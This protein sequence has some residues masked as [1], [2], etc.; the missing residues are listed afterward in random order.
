MKLIRAVAPYPHSSGDNFKNYVFRAWQKAGGAVAP[1]HYPPRL[2]H[3]FAFHHELPRLLSLKKQE[4]RLRFVQ[5]YSLSFDTWPDYAQYEIVPMI[6]DCWPK[7]FERTCHWLAKHHV[8]TAIFTASQTAERIHRRFPN[9]H[10]LF[11]PEGVDTLLYGAGRPLAERRINLL[12][13]GSVVR[14]WYKKR[15]PV[16]YKRLCA[17][18]EDCDLNSNDGFRRVLQDVKVTVVFPRCMTQAEEAGDVETLTQRYWEAMLTRVVMVGHAPSELVELVGYNPV[19]ELDCERPTEQIEDILRRIN[20]YQ[21]LVDRNRQT[22]L[23][24]G[25]WL[26]R[27][28]RLK[29]FLLECGYQL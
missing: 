9:M 13:I 25:D 6:W 16:D 3:H 8:R 18:P 21:A 1:A 4:A 10:I 24:M 14:S 20:D 29:Q 2:L 15:Y 19:I 23:A 7:E 11:L 28:K 22:A 5:P 27:M 26:K 17:M 12:E